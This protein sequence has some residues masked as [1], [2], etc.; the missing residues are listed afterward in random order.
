MA[1]TAWT[2]MQR[3]NL[4]KPVPLQASVSLCLKEREP[5][6][7]SQK[8]WGDSQ[9]TTPKKHSCHIREAVNPLQMLAIIITVA[10]TPIRG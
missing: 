8:G 1:H 7:L 9:T 3:P 4:T 2:Q 5:Q 10:V 6:R